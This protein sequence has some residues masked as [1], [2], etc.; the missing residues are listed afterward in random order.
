MRGRSPVAVFR[1]RSASWAAG[2]AVEELGLAG[3]WVCQRPPDF[4]GGLVREVVGGRGNG[5][6]RKRPTTPGAWHPHA[7][8]Q[9]Q[10]S[11]TAE[12]SHPTRDHHLMLA[13]GPLL[14]V[15]DQE[16]RDIQES[17]WSMGLSASQH[18]LPTRQ[19]CSGALGAIRTHAH[20][21][22]PVCASALRSALA[23]DTVRLTRGSR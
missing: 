7:E 10:S 18:G 2:Q 9:R 22:A 3:P 20:E 6:S 19:G 8:G 1:T 21:G 15:V 12:P 14:L 5:R 17:A 4:G 16:A 13:F 11:P 23:S